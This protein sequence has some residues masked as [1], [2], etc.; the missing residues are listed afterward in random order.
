MRIQ[1]YLAECGV[2]SR[3]ASERLIEDGRVRVN[4]HMAE[5]GQNIDPETD[6]ILVDGKP[7]KHEE[8]K[9]YLVINKPV[10]S[11][12]TASDTH[13]RRTV[14]D[15]VSSINARV[16]PVGRLDM[17]VEGVLILTNDGELAF[18]L[19]HPSY[20]VDKVYL[21]LVRGLMTAETAIR[22]EKGVELEDGLTA[23]AQA[24]ILNEG[25]RTTLVRL[26]LHEGRK[27]EVKRMCAAVGHPVR[28]LQ[29]I[30]FGN[31]QCK[32]LRPGEWRH[33]TRQE[34]DGLKQLADLG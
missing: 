3:R 6:N 24:V 18:R 12:T 16:F 1:K 4:G 7:V 20:E 9:V 26:T 31:V 2:A 33:L 8:E 14:I 11:V 28:R 27:R 34:L 5:I 21:V 17:D 19:T 13:G 23:P 10:G 22:L 25:E 29:R 32:G 15:F 30:A